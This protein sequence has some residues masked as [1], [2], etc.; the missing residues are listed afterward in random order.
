M[1]RDA[2]DSQTQYNQMDELAARLRDNTYPEILLAAREAAETIEALR[3]ERDAEK[4]KAR[5]LLVE[6][7]TVRMDLAAMTAEL[8]ELK[9][10]VW[11]LKGVR[12][13]KL[14]AS[15]AREQQLRE[16]L[17]CAINQVE[18]LCK[19]PVIAQALTLPQDTTAL[20]AWGTKLLRDA[21]IS[22]TKGL[23]PNKARENINRMA[24][25]LE[26]KK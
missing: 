13:E 8:A 11:Y 3:R 9:A 19:I 5:V 21:A 16:A 22:I 23:A 20:N 17:N 25:E 4:E 6:N 24:D 14:A 2:L 15:Q 1:I 18:S 12:D 10:N 7:N 26:G